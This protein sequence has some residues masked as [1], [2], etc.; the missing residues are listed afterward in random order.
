MRYRR[1]CRRCEAFEPELT[2]E[3]IERDGPPEPCLTCSRFYP[4]RFIE[5]EP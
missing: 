5:R 3:D 2:K 4:D 1:S